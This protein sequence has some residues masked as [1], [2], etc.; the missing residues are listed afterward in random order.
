MYYVL[1]DVACTSTHI[2]EKSDKKLH[3]KRPP[4]PFI[5]NVQSWW[6][7]N[8]WRLVA[9]DWQKNEGQLVNVTLF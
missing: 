3:I 9:R 1:G 4:I 5:W 6:S 2:F 7:E 8:R